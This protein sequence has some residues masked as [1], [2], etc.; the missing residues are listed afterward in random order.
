MHLATMLIL[1]I[2]MKHLITSILH[3][4]MQSL[5]IISL[6]M[7]L[8]IL[9]PNMFHSMPESPSLKPTLTEN[10]LEHNQPTDTPPTSTGSHPLK[11]SPA[12]T[13]ISDKV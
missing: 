2:K 12:S 5:A 11:N 6:I 7:L 8:M 4:K 13:N 3:N 1:V 10:P 9:L